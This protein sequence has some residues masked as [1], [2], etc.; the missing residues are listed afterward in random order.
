MTNKIDIVLKAITEQ[1]EGTLPS[2][3]VKNPK[4]SALPVLSAHS[5][6]TTIPQ[7][8]TQIHGSINAIT[9]QPMQQSDSHNDKTK[10]NEEEE[11]DS[12]ENNQPILPY[13]LISFITEKVLKFNSL[14][15]SLGL[16]PSS[17]SAEL[18]CPKAEDGNVMFIKIIP[19]DDNSYEE[20]MQEYKK[21]SISTYS[22]LEV[23]SRITSTSCVAQSFQYF[24]GTPS[25]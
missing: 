15:E 8:S 10:D 4:L 6:P 18:V 5:Y 9:V 17:P 11:K 16:V 25:L 19:K 24:Y 20:E 13:P 12:T 14:F 23:N 7:C 21:W 2:D 1:I 22:R 3:T